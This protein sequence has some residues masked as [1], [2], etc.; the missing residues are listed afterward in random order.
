MSDLNPPWDRDHPYPARLLSQQRLTAAASHKDVRHIDIDLA[1]SGLQYVPGDTLGI[2]FRNDPALVAAILQACELD[3]ATRVTV[4]DREDSLESALLHRFEL[5]QAHPGFIKH[6]AEATAHPALSQLAA[7]P[8]ALRA[9]L[10][11]RQVLDVLKQFPA[12]ITA[13]Q[14]LAC[15]RRMTPRQYSIASSPLVDPARVSLTVGMVRYEHDDETRTGA[16]SGF[17]GWRVHDGDRLPVFVIPNPNFRLPADPAAPIIMIGPGT[18]IAP[19][20]AFL[21][22]RAATKATGGEWLFFGNPHRATD[23]TYEDELNAHL[24]A[25]TLTKLDLAF[26]RDQPEKRYVQ[27]CLLDQAADVFA[28]LERGAYLYVCGDARHMAEDVQQA[29]LKLIAEQGKLDAAAARQY[30]VKMR[31]DKRYQR[32]VY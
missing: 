22:H 25:G 27:H 18:G 9:Y 14:L 31:Q 6:Y 7:D 16:A 2:W 29:L 19:F 17:L 15:L 3:P 23:F 1:D 28:W 12:P 13:A 5:T 4:D 30:L 10:D 11:Q 24:A 32:D 8:R 21:Q 20:R 26:S